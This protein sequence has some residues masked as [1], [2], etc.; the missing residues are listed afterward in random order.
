M[1][2]QF[3]HARLANGLTIVAEHDD[4]ALTAAAGFFVGTGARDE[5]PAVMG[6]SHFLE[7]MMFKGTPT[8]SSEQINQ[9]FDRLGA[10]ANAY[11]SSELTAFYA[12]TLPDKLP[13]AIEILADMMRPALREEDF[14]TERGVILEEIAMYA[15]D[16]VS[17]LYEAALEKHYGAH[18]LGHRVLGTKQTISD[19]SSEQMR[20]YFASRYS[21]DNTVLAL[22]GQVDFDAI[23][24]QLERMC[25]HWLP[26]SPGRDR[27]R[28]R[29]GGAT[30]KLSS[31]KINRAY[32]LTVAAGPGAHDEQRYAAFVLAQLLGGPD[33]SLLHWSLIET[34]LADSAQADFEPHDHAGDLR[35]LAAC[36]PQSIG[37]VRDTVLAQIAALPDLVTEADVA[38]VRAKVA[39]GVTL[40]GERPSGRMHRLGRHWLYFG[41]YST[42]EGELDKI[43]AVTVDD[44]RALWRS[45]DWA[46]QSLAVLTPAEPRN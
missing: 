32:L 34:G 9:E 26:T 43:N 23:V 17:V 15:D 4:D 33:N 42:L 41:S 28:P 39:T 29:V 16:P 25:G 10:A 5:A 30:V 13:K 11:T 37:D 3:K 21:A 44:V 8:R 46:G 27:A 7:H 40:A 22:A 31:D 24:R 20:G 12:A 19:L 35:V 6:V 38:R 36:E 45:V 14:Q 18:G 1:P 2:I